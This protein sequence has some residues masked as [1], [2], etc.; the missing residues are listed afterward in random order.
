MARG[1]LLALYLTAAVSLSIV[2]G[3]SHPTV[4]TLTIEAGAKNSI[5][6]L[7]AASPVIAI[8]SAK[9]AATPEKKSADSV[10]RKVCIDEKDMTSS[11]KTRCDGLSSCPLSVKAKAAGASACIWTPRPLT[12]TYTCVAATV[13]ITTSGPTINNK[14]K[15]RAGSA[16]QGLLDFEE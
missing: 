1:F 13:R 10:Q 14:V 2:H 3:E 8:S 15:V 12:V 5:K 9:F 6:C 16:V 4:T 7:N 11:V